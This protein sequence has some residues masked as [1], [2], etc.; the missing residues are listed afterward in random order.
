[1]TGVL[2]SDEAFRASDFYSPTML[3]QPTLRTARLISVRITC[4]QC[5]HQFKQFTYFDDLFVDTCVHR[6]EYK[7]E[8]VALSREKTAQLLQALRLRVM[9]S[10]F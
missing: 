3:I 2:L 9:I 7:A 1:V 10:G 8:K 4:K 5:G 6:L